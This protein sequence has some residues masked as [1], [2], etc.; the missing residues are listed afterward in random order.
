[1][2]AR[3]AR[4]KLMILAHRQYQLQVAI[5]NLLSGKGDVGYVT[6]RAKKLK[7]ICR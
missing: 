3:N 7:E 1:M 4:R 5:D 2:K 6:K